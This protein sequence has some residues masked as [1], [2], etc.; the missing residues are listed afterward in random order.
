MQQGW[1]VKRL[2]RDLVLSRTYRLSSSFDHAAAASDPENRW[3]W[4]MNRRRLQVEALRDSL[5]A[6]SEQLDRSPTESVVADLNVQATG[7]GIN[8]NKPVR[9]VR[10][11]VYL[12][13][14]R[15][16]LPALFQLFDFGDALSVNG[17]RRTT[18]VAPQAL[19]MMNSPLVLEAAN[20]TAA[21]VLAGHDV[22]DERQ[23]L[24]RFTLRI[25]GRSPLPDEI[26]PSLALVHA[27]L[28]EAAGREA[29]VDRSA[30]VRAWAVLSHALFCSTSFQY[31]D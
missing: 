12:P 24:E 22:C 28:S 7:V 18:N 30:R 23:L 4:R 27:V 17:R 3:L 15:N 31:V 25:L 11:T 2:I 9:S 1:S 13:V 21:S 8:P 26:E 5:L 10:R 16:D 19:F 6:V 20:R 29:A 14:I